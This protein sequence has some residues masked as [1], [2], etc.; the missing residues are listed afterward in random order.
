MRTFGHPVTLLYRMEFDDSDPEEATT[1][2]LV[3]EPP[4]L[5]FKDMYGQLIFAAGRLTWVN[6]RLPIPS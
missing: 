1:S 6:I 4:E 2:L 3:F 5:G